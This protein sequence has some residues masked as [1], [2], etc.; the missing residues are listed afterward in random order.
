MN[1]LSTMKGLRP[2]RVVCGKLQ[3]G[4]HQCIIRDLRPLCMNFGGLANFSLS[5][6]L[7]LLLLFG[8]LGCRGQV[9]RH[10]A[11]SDGEADFGL[12]ESFSACRVAT[13]T[14]VTTGPKH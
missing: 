3:L 12:G 7:R 1:G 5:G 4:R 13:L 6:A 10:S 9:C 8:F 2:A 11:R 14:L